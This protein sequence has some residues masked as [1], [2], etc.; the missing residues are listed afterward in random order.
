[1]RV[2]SN[3]YLHL[4]QAILNSRPF[5]LLSRGRVGKWFIPLACVALI[6]SYVFGEASSWASFG[7]LSLMCVLVAVLSL[8]W[9]DRFVLRLLM[10]NFEWMFL[11]FIIVLYVAVGFWQ[12]SVSDGRNELRTGNSG[13]ICVGLR[14][15]DMS[16]ELRVA[17]RRKT[18][19]HLCLTLL[20]RC[21]FYK[22]QC[23]VSKHL[24]VP[25]LSRAVL[26]PVLWFFA[27]FF[28]ISLDAI[29]SP[30]RVLRP[31]V[32]SIFLANQV[33]VIVKSSLNA[34]LVSG[35]PYICLSGDVH[36]AESR[37]VNSEAIR[38]Q[39]FATI[40]VF[41]LKYAVACARSPGA[42]MIMRVAVSREALPH[43][44]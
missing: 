36:S 3:L 17:R 9:I 21:V 15:C 42:L 32:I 14:E 13:T 26:W 43:D 25:Y 2:V 16:V 12:I 27:A 5:V 1:M 29:V 20:G 10:R 8:G 24:Q 40:T 35:A 44:A 19:V 30:S 22:H 11:A 34:N 28:C 6:A 4:V 41:A 23:I 31:L 37:C 38:L 18:C 33:I 7:I 39:M